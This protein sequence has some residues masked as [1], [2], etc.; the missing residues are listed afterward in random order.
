MLILAEPK[1]DCHCHIVDPVGFP[2]AEGVKYRPTGQEIGPLDQFEAVCAT[3]GVAHALIVGPNS[4]YGSDNRCLLDALRRSGA[5]FK[6]IAVVDNDASPGM[7]ADLKAN[8]VVGIAINATYHGVDHYLGIGPLIDRMCELGL[9][10]QIQ[11]E[12]DQLVRLMPL[13]ERTD[14]PVLI[15]HCGRP[16]LESGLS[17]PGFR[18]LCELGRSGRA[19][20]KL[21]GLQKFSRQRYPYDDTRPFVKALVEAFGLERCIWGSDWP[22]LRAEERL[23]YGPLLT[24]VARHFPDEA[25]RRMLLWETPRRL[26]GFGD[27]S[28]GQPVR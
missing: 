8:G 14:I 24:L 15:D 2:Y 3:Y 9:M 18:A 16:I 26:F 17:Q 25:Q 1:I 11:V 10:L 13:V 22:Y 23:D 5:R 21:S 12:G 20:I 28:D 27:D 4:G 6:G 7:L 19:V